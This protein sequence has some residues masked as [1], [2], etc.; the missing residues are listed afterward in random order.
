[1][2]GKD[3]KNE[4]RQIHLSDLLA[5]YDSDRPGCPVLDID[6]P[7]LDG[8]RLQQEL[9]ERGIGIPIIFLTGQA[10]VPKTVQAFK[11]GAVDLR[12][13]RSAPGQQ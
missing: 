7:G 12:R 5:A 10:D 9:A 4:S 1:M 8:L 13:D 2:G 11:S 6:T 3:L